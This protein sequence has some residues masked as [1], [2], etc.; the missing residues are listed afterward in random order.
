MLE[1]DMTDF[2]IDRKFDC[3]YSNKVL[4]HLSAAKLQT[5]LQIQVCHINQNG[6]IL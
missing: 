5:S 6:I 4:Y 2:S 1:F 3:I